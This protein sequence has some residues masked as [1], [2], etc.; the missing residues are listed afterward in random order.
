MTDE[1]QPPAEDD[2]PETLSALVRQYPGAVFAG[3]LALGL[4]AGALLPKRGPG[5]L[6][7]SKLGARV[8]A[9][10]SAAGQ[11]GVTLGQQ[12]LER[13]QDAARETRERLADLGESAG[14]ASADMRA[15]MRKAGLKLARKAVEF[16]AKAK[17]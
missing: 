10:A 6:G 1:T 7:Q 9:A 17:K 14:D 15:D 4:L 8:L 2:L 16:A 11:L 5:K 13:S 12:A 3:G